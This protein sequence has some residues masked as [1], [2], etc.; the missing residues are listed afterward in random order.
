MKRDEDDDRCI[1]SQG[2]YCFF[3]PNVHIFSF[4]SFYFSFTCKNGFG[5]RFRT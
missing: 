4:L 2:A 5:R 1:N 3:I